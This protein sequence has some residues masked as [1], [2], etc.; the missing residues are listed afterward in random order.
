MPKK[1]CRP[2][3][4]TQKN[5]LWLQDLTKLIPVWIVSEVFQ[6]WKFCIQFTGI[7]LS[8]YTILIC[9]TSWVCRRF[10]VDICLVYHIHTLCGISISELLCYITL[11]MYNGIIGSAEPLNVMQKKQASKK[12][13]KEKIIK[14]ENIFIYATGDKKKLTRKTTLQNETNGSPVGVYHLPIFY[15]FQW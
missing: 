9:F 3:R 15:W 6:F 13:W 11:Y 5:E 7:Y 4:D 12:M 1:K 14:Y 2:T 8:K 10:L